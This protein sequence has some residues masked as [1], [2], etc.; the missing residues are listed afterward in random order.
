[1]RPLPSSR[2]LRLGVDAMAERIG[3][4]SAHRP[5]HD[6]PALA[7]GYAERF[8]DYLEEGYDKGCPA[9]APLVE[10]LLAALG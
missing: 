9:A 10:R 5:P 2:K 4:T 3:V 7:R 1:M 8:L 6:W